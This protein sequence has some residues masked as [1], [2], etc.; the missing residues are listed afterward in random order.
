MVIA[1]KRNLRQTVARM[2][3]VLIFNHARNTLIHYDQK[4]VD[5][6]RKIAKVNVKKI[7]SIRS[8]LKFKKTKKILDNLSKYFFLVGD[9][10]DYPPCDTCL[11][12]GYKI[13]LKDGTLVKDSRKYI[14]D[15]AY[16]K[17]RIIFDKKIT[18][19]YEL[20]EKSESPAIVLS[21]ITYPCYFIG[22]KLGKKTAKKNIVF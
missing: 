1:R 6:F 21:L 9:M 2:K 17:D 3:T 13:K 7:D 18:E 20:K 19:I 15:S 11:I 12:S 5:L 16:L 8:K 22:E 14:I 4:G 10:F